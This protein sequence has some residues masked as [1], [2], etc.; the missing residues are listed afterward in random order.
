MC[1]IILT[2]KEQP[3]VTLEADTITPYMFAR[4]QSAAERIIEREQS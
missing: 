2:P 3:Q 1:E 4:L